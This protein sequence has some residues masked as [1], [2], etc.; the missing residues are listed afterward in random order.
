MTDRELLES[1]IEPMKA[2]NSWARLPFN[3]RQHMY[4][5][6]D[7]IYRYKRVVIK[8]AMRLEVAKL[9]LISLERPCKTCKGTGQFE[10][11]DYDGEYYDSEDCRR[12]NA[13]GK[14]TLRFVVSEIFGVRWHTPRPKWDL[15]H[16][17]PEDWEKR[18]EP[19]TEWEPERPGKPLPFIELVENLNA[20]E[21]VL[22]PPLVPYE[23]WPAPDSRLPRYSLHF[24]KIW[25]CPF[26]GVNPARGVSPDYGP[27]R[28][29]YRPCMRWIQ[30]P[31]WRHEGADCMFSAYSK[32]FQWPYD[33]L[34]PRCDRNNEDQWEYHVPLPQLAKHPAVT[35]WLARRGIIIG[36]Y[37]P[38]ECVW[39][40]GA[41]LLKTVAARPDGKLL[42]RI[43]DSRDWMD[44]GYSDRSAFE[45]P[46]SSV[47]TRQ[48]GGPWT[49][50]PPIDYPLVQEVSQ[51]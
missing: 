43:Y 48:R 50:T 6:T 22:L 8:A 14:V 10:R 34:P 33:L 4:E 23:S 3:E 44:A 20:V 15:D 24:G 39:S 36:A 38:D 2:L 28:T 51:C 16:F 18:C 21:R 27:V 5:A 35:E 7:A 19:E 32:P 37:P 17:T 26:C 42:V 1:I 46:V 30:D 25:S 11:T 31:C 29:I 12:C 9:R 47:R 40:Q 13:S 49:T 45:V 41:T